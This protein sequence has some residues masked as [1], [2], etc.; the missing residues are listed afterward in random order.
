MK[1]LGTL[2]IT[3]V[4]SYSYVSASAEPAY[5]RTIVNAADFGVRANSYENASAAIV[6]A[7]QFCKGKTGITLRL[8]EGR[9]DVW[10]EYAE[11]RELFISNGT[12]TDTLSKQKNIAF[13]LV[14]LQDFEL[15]GQNTLVVL[16]GKMI[17]FAVLDSRDIKISGIRF[18]YE[19]PTMSEFT[20]QAIS[21]TE[22]TLEVHPKSSYAI[23]KGKFVLYGEGWKS[24][25]HHTI[26]LDSAT[27][28]MYYSNWRATEQS[29]AT[30]LATGLVQFKGDFSK[31]NWKAGDRLSVRDPYRDNTGALIWKSK[32]ILLRDLTMHYMHGL[33][34]VSQFSE[35][36]SLVKVR[37]EPPAESGRV[38]SSFADCFHFSGCKGKIL[39][40][41]CYTSGAHDDPI[42]VHGTHLKILAVSD[43]RKLRVGFMHHQTYG[44]EAFFQGDSVAY[45]EA[46]TLLP[47]ALGKVKQAGMISRKEM[48]LE[49]E[50]D[51]PPGIEKGHVLENLTWT[52]E[53]EIRNSHFERTNT[54]GILVTTRKKVVIDNNRFVRTGMHAILIADDASSWYE[55]GPVQDLLI[56]NNRFEECGFNSGPGNHVIAIAPEN[57]RLVEKKYVHKNIRIQNN[58]FK[59]YD[60]PLVSAR[61][62]DGLVFSN[63]TVELSPLFPPKEARA[64][65]HLTASTKVTIQGNK[66]QIPWPL[67]IQYENMPASAIKAAGWQIQ[68]IKK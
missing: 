23:E 22:T 65:F 19:R 44:I 11:K 67:I 33:G 21:P 8:P 49:M 34:I 7:V 39:I 27:D 55:S 20:V 68:G 66:M 28:M 26:R 60:A 16:H 17:S 6:R 59:V 41:S 31:S 35:N 47:I 12:E 1:K 18:D 5:E 62:V 13:L 29:V 15:E 4:F 10:P 43:A 63:N 45:V 46:A 14:N 25:S 56:Q 58:Y 2:L 54:R 61:S 53:L 37:V 42:N 52:P 50:N 9:I 36:I 3:L 30:E 48:E 57:H 32:D 40:D 64:S 51:L 24:K 38:I